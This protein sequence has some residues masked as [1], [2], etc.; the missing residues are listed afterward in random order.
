MTLMLATDIRFAAPH[1][2]F[3]L[4]EVKR[5][6]FPANG[7]TQR[8]LQQLP[9]PIAM[10]MLLTGDLID[11]ETAARWGLINRIVPAPALLETAMDT[12]RHIARNAP[13][14]VQSAKELA[15]RSRDL[16]LPSGLRLE[17]AMLRL[18][19]TSEDVQEG[20]KAFAEKRQP[21]FRGR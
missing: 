15:V 3:G 2:T 18:L 16:D 1:A 19:Q 20:T 8:L 9:Y 7:G 10:D 13:L 5:G 12:A 6:I 14:A 21:V 11:A 4:S 17:Q